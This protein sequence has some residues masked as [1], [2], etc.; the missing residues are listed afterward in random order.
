MWEWEKNRMWVLQKFD[1]F[2]RA[3]GFSQPG[4]PAE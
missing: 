4:L 2:E 1:T 3:N